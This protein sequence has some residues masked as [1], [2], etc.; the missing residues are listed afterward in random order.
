M[1]KKS[2]IWLAIFAILMAL[3][4]IMF[5]AVFCLRNQS[6]KVIDGSS[7]LID[8]SEI[9]STAGLQNGN[10]IFMLD[11]ETAINNVEARYPHL[12]VVQIKTIGLRSIEIRVRRRHEMYYAQANEKYYVLDEDLKVLNIIEEISSESEP[13]NLTKIETGEIEIDSTTKIC[14]FVGTVHQRKVAYE[15]FVAMNTAVTKIDG[16]NEVYLTRD[17][18][19][20]ML[21]NVDLETYETFDK[22]IIKTKH[23]VMLDIENP[24]SNL[25]TKINICFSTIEE[26]INKANDKEKS[27]TIKIYY[28]LENEMQCVYIP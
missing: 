8:K 9:I 21:V 12:K 20:E 17:D 1:T 7:L 22:L 4:G 24:Q 25:Q 19:K 27:G 14:D 13:T 23:G 2:I 18:I 5:G 28:N 11:K 15:L 6:V 10:S 16:E 3:T 26:F